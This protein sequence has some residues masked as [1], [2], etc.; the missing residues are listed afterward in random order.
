MAED[1]EDVYVS[2][3]RIFSSGQFQTTLSGGSEEFSDSFLVQSDGFTVSAPG[4][5]S[6]TFDSPNH[7]DNGSM[8]ITEPYNW[9][10]NNLSELIDF[11][12]ALTAST[13]VTLTL[14]TGE[15]ETLTAPVFSDDTGDAQTWTVGTAITAVTVPEATGSPTPAYAVVGSL[16]AGLA[17]DTA[18]RVLSGMPTGVG[19]GTITIRATNSE[20]SDDWTV[21]YV[22]SAVALPDATAPTVTIAAVD[23]VYADDTVELT[24]SVTGGTYDALSYAW[25]VVSG[26]GSLTGSGDSRTY[27]PSA[28]ETSAEIRV[29]VTATG[30]GT[31]YADG[32]SDTDDR[33]GDLHSSYSDHAC[34]DQ[35]DW[36]GD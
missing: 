3:V 33:Y 29:T 28:G 20:G 25:E 30:D 31:S 7:P 19:S 13:V 15:P 35:H 26:G 23:F 18:T 12:T 17:F 2:Q 32:S 16:P 27:N 36:P 9:N 1:S 5:P 11:F 22:T 34:V 4:I 21:D 10:P 6:V 24:A 8:D 14:R